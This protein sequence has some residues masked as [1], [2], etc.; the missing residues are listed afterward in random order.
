MPLFPLLETV[1]FIKTYYVE[2]SD[3]SGTII[4]LQIHR[5]HKYG[6]ENIFIPIHWKI[7]L[8]NALTSP[9]FCYEVKHGQWRS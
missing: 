6:N 1:V 5:N 2:K 4:N 8:N 7:F 9:I 3:E